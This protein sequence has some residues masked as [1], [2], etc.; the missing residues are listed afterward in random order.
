MVKAIGGTDDR[1]LDVAFLGDPEAARATYDAGSGA[2]SHGEQA[3]ARQR[4][5]GTG[6]FDLHGVLLCAQPGLV[7]LPSIPVNHYAEHFPQRI[8]E[9]KRYFGMIRMSFM[10]A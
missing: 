7:D 4:D 1:I 9:D 8:Q 3:V 10:N 6:D 2:V 5:R